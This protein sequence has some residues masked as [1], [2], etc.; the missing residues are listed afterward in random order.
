MLL[1]DG[2]EEGGRGARCTCSDATRTLG[3]S[4]KTANSNRNSDIPV[5][6]TWLLKVGRC[7]AATVVAGA[8]AEGRMTHLFDGTFCV[9]FCG[10][11]RA[12]FF[13]PPLG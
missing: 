3:S 10:V 12:F 9:V 6:K 2:G 13:R 5:E 8:I 4:Q 11:A 1:E 7:S